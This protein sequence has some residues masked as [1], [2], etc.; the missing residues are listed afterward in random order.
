M[1][2]LVLEAAE[3]AEPRAVELERGEAVVF[4]RPA[5]DKTSGNEDAA[6]VFELQGGAVVLAV[7]DGLG[8]GP[9]GAQA[10]SI[11]MRALRR[12]LGREIAA[13]SL[14]GVILDAFEDANREVLALGIGAGTT[15]VVVE[16]A[17][18]AARAYH[19]G[20]SGALLVGQ[21]GR[22]GFETMHHSPVGYGVAAGVLEHDDVHH[23]EERHLLLNCVG[24]REMRVEI[25]API[26]MAAR[27]TVLLASDGVLDNLRRAELVEIV[28]AGELLGAARGLAARVY[29]TMAGEDPELPPHP[30]DATA[31]L[32][33]RTRPSGAS[34]RRR[35]GR[36]RTDRRKPA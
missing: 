23:H 34:E 6:A 24:S 3:L 12:A 11:A 15:L 5:P 7:A 29:E 1:N 32:Y 10:A 27:D 18:G 21:R 26:R 2:R 25:G 28:R 36:R 8:G 4:S 17:G 13:D 16:V 9:A 22:I 20:D 19:A 35:S 30:D 14:R 33:R 31:L